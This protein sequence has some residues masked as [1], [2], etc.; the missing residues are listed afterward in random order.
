M[1]ARGKLM[2]TFRQITEGNDRRAS[3]LAL[4][5]MEIAAGVDKTEA[6][7]RAEI[8]KTLAELNVKISENQ[9]NRIVELAKVESAAQDR[10]L[11][12]EQRG[13]ADD[14]DNY[15]QI[16]LDYQQRLEKVETA[17]NTA[18]KEP[19]NMSPKAA[20]ELK[21]KRDSAI[22]RL[23]NEYT[24]LLNQY[25]TRLGLNLTSNSIDSSPEQKALDEIKRRAGQ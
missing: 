21:Q 25:E 13:L 16:K 19:I 9:L 5:T 15:R 17:Y 8:G 18:A 2:D 11:T 22:S 12:R 10:R 6:Q 3:E 14:R 4:K 7:I 1:D 20:A 24:P 23:Q